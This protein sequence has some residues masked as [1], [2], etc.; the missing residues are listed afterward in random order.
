QPADGE[1]AQRDYRHRV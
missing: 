1:G